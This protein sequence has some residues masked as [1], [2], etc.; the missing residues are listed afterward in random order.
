M[1]IYLIAILIGIVMGISGFIAFL[2][3]LATDEPTGFFIVLGGGFPF[4]LPY[5]CSTDYL[6]SLKTK[7]SAVLV[8]ATSR[9]VI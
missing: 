1:L 5:H 9:N 7:F 3:L 4:R 8:S 6:F 2:R